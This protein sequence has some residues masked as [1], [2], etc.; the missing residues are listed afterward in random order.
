MSATCALGEI[1]EP[2][3]G[4]LIPPLRDDNEEVRVRAA[5]ILKKITG[6]DFSED[7]KEWQ[8]WWEQNKDKFLK[9]R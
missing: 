9:S 1:A 8:E 3:V 6:K 2:A 5:A 4:P 7:S